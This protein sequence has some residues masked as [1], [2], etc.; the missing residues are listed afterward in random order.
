MEQPPST[1]EPLVIV[2]G[3]AALDSVYRI[4][5]FP[6]EPAKVR[7]LEH[8]ECG[9]GSAAN[10]AAAIAHLGG[11]VEFWSRTGADETGRRIL[12]SLRKDGVPTDYVRIHSGSRSSQ[13]A[14]IVDERGER[15]IVSERD[16][17]MP[18]TIDG[19]P[20][21]HIASAAAVLSDLRWFEATFAAF[22][23][24]RRLNVPSLLDIDVGGGGL[25]ERFIPMTDYAIF[26]AQGL[27]A[28]AGEGPH[29]E[30]LGMALAAGVRHAGVTLGAEGY[31][32]RT[33]VGEQGY[34][35]AFAVRPVIDTTGA[36]DAF[37][38]AFA[39]A[40]AHGRNDAECA[41]IAAAVA[42]L[43]VRRLGAR[44]GLPLR[45]ELEALLHNG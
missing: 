5:Q 30:L 39:W 31:L 38:G 18:S 24:A 35:P 3:H 14:V 19:L 2:I 41:R 28:Y 8:L 36:G 27:K 37:H 13:A 29:M 10:A 6:P 20:I 22:A 9:G 40:L 17:A 1:V 11:K 12:D 26:S 15:L 16:H 34:Q 21:A 33:S 32:W 45:E 25:A 7:A 43:S 23:E 42:A 4:A 44:A